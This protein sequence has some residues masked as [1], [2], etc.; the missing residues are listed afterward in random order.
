VVRSGCCIRSDDESLLAEL[1]QSKAL[2]KLGLRRIAPT[3]LISAC[4]EKETLAGL[5]AAGY[6]PVLEAESG[7][8]LIEQPPTRR[9]PTRRS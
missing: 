7:A 8:T 5:R 1:A 2:R 4:P 9:A 3:V 6:T